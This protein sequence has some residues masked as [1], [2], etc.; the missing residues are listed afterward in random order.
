LIETVLA[1]LRGVP[2]L[3]V[4]RELLVMRDES[5]RDER[6]V[7]QLAAVQFFLQAVVWYSTNE[8]HTALGRVTNYVALL[9]RLE[10]HRRVTGEDY[11]FVT[12]NYD[13]LLEWAAET[14]DLR[15]FGD[16]DAY[17][18]RQPFSL[19]KP[20]GSVN[21]VQLAVE[22]IP[23]ETYD[24]VPKLIRH[25]GEI[26]MTQ[27]YAVANYQTI[28]TADGR[29]AYPAIAIPLEAKS[30]FACPEA[31]LALLE[32]VCRSATRLVTIGCRGREAHFHHRFAHLLTGVDY[33]L[34]ADAGSG[35]TES[36]VQHLTEQ[37][38]L[39]RPGNVGGS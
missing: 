3:D 10:N 9:D 36:I 16:I 39:N 12:F 26:E 17:L 18:D 32:D 29:I 13:L 19:T 33:A 28:K 4:E 15:G 2:S 7:Q 14:A 6:R 24:D 37:G 35:N 30:D 34:V 23:A 22:R 1:R 25:R 21:W 8:W 38:A 20:H 27:E 11:A 5:G 31:H